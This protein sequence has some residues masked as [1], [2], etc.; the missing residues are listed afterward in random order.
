MLLGCCGEVGEH[1][2]GLVAEVM[3]DGVLAGVCT[4]QVG[5]EVEVKLLTLGGRSNKTGVFLFFVWG[6][7]CGELGQDKG[8]SGFGWTWVRG[9][10]GPIGL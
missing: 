10:L 2:M 5:K 3:E 6:L 1:G 7:G 8:R 9:S 4:G